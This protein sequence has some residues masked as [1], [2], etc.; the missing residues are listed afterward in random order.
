MG[1]YSHF[2]RSSLA[3]KGNKLPG[4]QLTCDYFFGVVG[5]GYERRE[6]R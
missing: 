1:G 5:F 4:I 3:A 6:S 2:G